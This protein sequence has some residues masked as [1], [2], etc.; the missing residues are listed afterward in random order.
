MLTRPHHRFPPPNLP[1]SHPTPPHLPPTADLIDC[2]VLSRQ[3][4]EAEQFARADY[5][6]IIDPNN[7]F[8]LEGP[9]LGCRAGQYAEVTYQIVQAQALALSAS[10][11]PPTPAAVDEELSTLD[12]AEKLAMLSLSIF[13]KKDG[14]DSRTASLA[15]SRLARIVYRKWV[16]PRHNTLLSFLVPR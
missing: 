9:L 10:Q 6:V 13:A 11:H 4:E 14:D 15:R 8:D 2:C 1:P 3:L 12:F 16:R 5:L 7:G